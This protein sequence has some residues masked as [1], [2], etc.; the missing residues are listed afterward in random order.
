MLSAIV[1]GVRRDECA[2]VVANVAF[3]QHNILILIQK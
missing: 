3:L 1:G 2:V